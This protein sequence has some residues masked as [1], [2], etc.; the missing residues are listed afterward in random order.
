MKIMLVEWAV[1]LGSTYA[2]HPEVLA[3]CADEVLREDYDE[4]LEESLEPLLENALRWGFPDSSR[5]QAFLVL[6]R[7]LSRNFILFAAF[8]EPPQPGTRMIVK[9]RY[10]RPLDFYTTARHG[11]W[12]SLERLKYLAKRFIGVEYIDLVINASNS[13]YAR[14]YHFELTT[15]KDVGLK[16]AGLFDEASEAEGKAVKWL[17]PDTSWAPHATRFGI[18]PITTVP[19]GTRGRAF[20]R[21]APFRTL[22][23]VAVLFAS[24]LIAGILFFCFTDRPTIEQRSDAV[25]SAAALFLTAFLPTVLGREEMSFARRLLVPTRIVAA[26]VSTIPVIVAMG[27]VSD[28]SFFKYQP[29]L[30]VWLAAIASAIALRQL[31]AV[32][33]S[34]GTTTRIYGR[35]IDRLIHPLDRRRSS[36][37]IRGAE[38]L[39]SSR[40]DEYRYEHEFLRS[41]K[42]QD[43]IK[44]AATGAG[45]ATAVVCRIIWTDP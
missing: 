16:G 3:D 12:M 2:D 36:Q 19:W 25:F 40:L 7:M 1:V 34:V 33:L 32:C 27:I 38:L 35:W 39:T 44:S 37:F 24:L 21:I 41:G 23:M 26:A 6:A 11:R 30:T 4:N 18:Y 31:V 20:F 10:D 22:W 8:E 15:P 17:G 9:Y 5:A 42:T 13:A 14:S 29:T 43:V 45:P 28:A